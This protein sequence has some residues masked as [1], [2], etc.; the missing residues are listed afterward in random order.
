MYQN[1]ALLAAFAFMYSVVAGGL[2]R[3]WVNGAVVFTLFGVALGPLGLGWLQL[4][5]DANG[6]RLIAELTLAMVLFTDAAHA[7]LGVLKRNVRIPERLLMLSLPLT[8][9]F[10]FAVAWLL[11]DHLSMLEMAILATMLAPT[12]AALGK[13]V[14]SDPSVPAPIREGLNFESGLNDGICVPILFLLLAL[15]EGQRGDHGISILALHLMAEEIGIGVLVAM[16]VSVPGAWLLKRCSR[17]QWLEESWLQVPVV[18]M[19]V[20]CF[21]LAQ[22]SGGSGF[23]AAFIGGLVFGWLTKHHPLKHVILER[24]EGVGDLFSLITWVA[25]GAVVISKSHSAFDWHILLYSILSL[26]VIRMLPVFVSLAGLKLA[27]GEK[28]FIGWFGPRGLASIVFA[29]IVYN[30]D[31]PGVHTISMTVVCTIILSV[32]LHGLSATPLVAAL[33]QRAKGHAQTAKS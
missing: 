22:A 17:H 12:D 18:A 32:L 16:V 31:L 28:L 24:A 15:A 1:L 27:L 26:T 19:A 2:A 30:S 11:F 6:I 23:I 4:T 20:T 3:T 7:D 8:I 10:G 13:A 29:V 14:V 25:F 33:A 5:L 9:L 21:A